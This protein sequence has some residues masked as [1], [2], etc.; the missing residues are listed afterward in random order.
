MREIDNNE[1][2]LQDEEDA[3]LVGKNFF[4]RWWLR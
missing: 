2:A 3:E 1:A 4:M